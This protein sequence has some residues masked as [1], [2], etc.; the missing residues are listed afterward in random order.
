MAGDDLWN[1]FVPSDHPDAARINANAIQQARQ[2]GFDND[3]IAGH[4]VTHLLGRLGATSASHGGGQ[5]LPPIPQGYQLE[6][7]RPWTKYQQPPPESAVQI[8]PAHIK[9]AREAGY[10]D[11]EIAN[12]LAQRFPKQFKEAPAT[13]TRQPKSWTI[14]QR[15][16][17]DS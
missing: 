5:A 4:L 17:A 8:D 2:R 14:C 3:E 12:F 16:T 13:A 9:A 15:G 1:S 11:G 10:Q 7:G 6:E